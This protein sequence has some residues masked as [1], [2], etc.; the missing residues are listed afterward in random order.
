MLP[1]SRGSMRPRLCENALN[2]SKTESR[3]GCLWN[4]RAEARITLVSSIDARNAVW[5][6]SAAQ[7]ATNWRAKWLDLRPDR[8]KQ[9]YY[10]EDAH[11][12]FEVVGEHMKAH[13]GTY[14]R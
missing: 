3:E 5:A 13:L 7:T 11:H 14:P 6:A 12:S 10:A 1:V 9:S 4:Q 2:T 8:L